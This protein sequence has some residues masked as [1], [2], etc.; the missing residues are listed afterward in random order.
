MTKNI[1]LI[2]AGGGTPDAPI[3]T[4]DNLF[5][6]DVAEIVLGLCEGEIVGLENGMKSFF[7]GTVPFQNLDGTYNFTA[8]QP[9]EVYTGADS[10]PEV[11]FQLGGES[12]NY[13]PSVLLRKDVPVTQVSP[14]VLRGKLTTIEIRLKFEQL[15]SQNE[16]G[17]FENTAQFQIAYKKASAPDS[18]YQFYG[19]TPTFLLVGKTTGGYVKELRLTGLPANADDD[20]QIRITKLSPDALGQTGDLDICE[21]TWESIQYITNTKRTYPGLAFVH[22][23]AETGQEFTS[24][25][26]FYGIYLGLKLR[27]P[28]N[29]NGFSRITNLGTPWSG[30]TFKE[31]WTDNPVWFTYNVI[32]NPKFGLAHHYKDISVNPF[33]FYEAA[34]YCDERVPD[35]QGGTQ[36]RYSMNA[37]LENALDGIEQLKNVAG[38]FGGTV[39]DGL[40][41]KLHLR[42]DKWREP[43][44]LFTPECVP[45]EQPFS[46]SFADNDSRYNDVTVSFIN[47]D[48]DWQVDKRRITDEDSIL[49]DGRIPLEFEAM[50]CIDVHEATRKAYMRMITSR[51][52]ITT[53][54]FITTRLGLLLSPFDNIWISDPDMGWGMTGRVES[55]QAGDIL[56]REP[57]YFET[58]TTYSM[59]V[60]TYAEVLE[61]FITPAYV[62]NC[63]VLKIFGGIPDTTSWPEHAPFSLQDTGNFGKVKP[64]RVLQVEEVEG[65]PD[66]Y[67]ISALEVNQLKYEA[68]D[69]AHSVGTLPYSYRQPDV[70]P[71]P[72]GLILQA[73][74]G[75]LQ[76]NG[77]GT[78]ASRITAAWESNKASF[79]DFFEVQYAEVGTGQWTQAQTRG[80]QLY[81]G[82][83]K[84]GI[85]YDVGVRA[86][87]RLGKK[88]DWL[89]GQVLVLGKTAPP[90]DVQNFTYLNKDY[91]VRL[92]WD[93]VPDKDVNDY[94][95]RAYADS[96][97]AAQ[98]LTTVGNATEYAWF[99]QQ[100]GTHTMWIKA[101]DTSGNP[102]VNA[103]SVDVLIG[104]PGVPILMLRYENSNIVLDWTVPS[105]SFP[106][107]DYEVRFSDPLEV[108][109]NNAEVMTRTS[110]QSLRLQ[111]DF[112]G[113]RRFWVA[114]VDAAENI[115]AF[116]Y[117]DFTPELPSIQSLKAEIIDNNVL[118]RWLDTPG[119]LPIVDHIVSKGDDYGT[120]VEVFHSRG[121]FAPIFERQAGLNRYWVVPEDSAGNLGTPVSIL[122]SVNQPPDYVL[123]VDQD[124]NFEDGTKTHLFHDTFENTLIGAVNL[125]ETYDDHFSDHGYATWQD[126]IDDGYPLFATPG[127]TD[128]EYIYEYDYT[129]LLNSAI[130]AVLVDQRMINGTLV[131]EHLD[132][133]TRKLITDP[134]T[135]YPDVFSVAVGE[136]R[137]LKI[138]YYGTTSSDAALIKIQRINIRLDTKKKKEDGMV[139]VLAADVSGTVVVFDT[140]LYDITSIKLSLQGNTPGY[141]T[142]DFV[143]APN[144]TQ[145][146]IYAYDLAGVRIDGRVSWEITGY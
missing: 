69:N 21:I 12:S 98:F 120:S 108:D 17:V 101:I 24:I 72:Y 53:V 14:T 99:M 11:T 103:T 56:L 89:R 137:Y 100:E 102:S 105:A 124:I 85:Y 86:V 63:T 143:D 79:I 92:S 18:T 44:V 82:P 127:Y 48:L 47:P 78:I 26:D 70:P 32:M 113:D 139:D 57:I 29:Y 40:N 39:F 94:E 107:V 115:G 77:D 118:L 3:Q 1:R 51:T 74:T 110:T 97:E 133:S 2:G 136:F 15:F 145:F 43:L 27:V 140:S 117:A 131:A 28:T 111:A 30:S 61:I 80:N 121:T 132:I 76:V 116:G 66:W 46:Y 37:L 13:N 6:K 19:N 54:N 104:T 58:L 96:W 52:E 75:E 114:A 64:F 62:G 138:R 31:E 81:L 126:A 45:P 122:G 35:G 22:I 34:Q 87:N 41:G 65:K 36:P 42:V 55:V 88:S 16:S 49:K 134:W 135:D 4:D 93:K 119:T 10:D 95:L 8:L 20:W 33:D 90:S 7:V 5:S 144:P 125:T 67:R 68:A 142:Y 106:I 128:F 50:G 9:P 123:L 141:A 146:S 84:D 83:V 71:K 25:P 109:P 60:Q 73:S 38:S 112:T 23:I 129:T 91:G 59:L 130:L